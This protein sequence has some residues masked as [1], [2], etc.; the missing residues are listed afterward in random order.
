MEVE[1]ADAAIA[2]ANATRYS[3]TAAVFT[4]DLNA[5]L[6]ASARIRAGTCPLPFTPL[7]CLGRRADGGAGRVRERE[8]AD[9]PRRA[10]QHRVRAQV[11][12][13]PLHFVFLPDALTR[14]ASG[15]AVRRGMAGSTSTRSRTAARPSCTRARS[16][17]RSLTE[18]ARPAV[19]AAGIGWRGWGRS[20]GRGG[21][22]RWLIDHG[23][24]IAVFT[25]SSLYVQYWE[26]AT[27]LDTG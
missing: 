20:G 22:V 10:E 18:C 24:R 25:S 17:T 1:D 27:E 13:R 16:C 11:R 7:W 21:E 9:V 23:Q 3:L 4:R 26:V 8:R 2:A 15:A 14:A 6:D 19:E 5:A 12:A